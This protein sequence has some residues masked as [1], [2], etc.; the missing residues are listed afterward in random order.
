MFEAFI[1]IDVL[2]HI[3][4]LKK[5][6]PSREVFSQ[7][8]IFNQS[9]SCIFKGRVRFQTSSRPLLVGCGPYYKRFMSPPTDHLVCVL[10]MNSACNYANGDERAH[11]NKF[12]KCSL[13][14]YSTNEGIIS[15]RGLRLPKGCYLCFAVIVA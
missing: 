1:L 11:S 4:V 2:C 5:K 3:I 9:S 7:P 10:I 13:P 15:Y 8:Q 6:L 14:C 12:K